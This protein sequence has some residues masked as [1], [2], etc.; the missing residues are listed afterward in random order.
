MKQALSMENLN[1]QVPFFWEEGRPQKQIPMLEFHSVTSVTQG[2]GPA[3]SSVQYNGFLPH[4]LFTEIKE[5]V[6]GGCLSNSPL[7]C[8]ILSLYRGRD[9]EK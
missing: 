8:S 5:T 3:P 6:V 2:S 9:V 1:V 7:S 4:F